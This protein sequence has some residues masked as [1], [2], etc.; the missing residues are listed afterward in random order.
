MSSLGLSL[1]SSQSNFLEIIYTTSL[2]EDTVA[3]PPSITSRS[4]HRI[5]MLP[6]TSL[7]CF[8]FYSTLFLQFQEP[9]ILM[10]DPE[11]PIPPD[12]TVEQCTDWSDPDAQHSPLREPYSATTSFNLPFPSEKLFLLSRGATSGLVKIVQSP[13]I[14]E[15]EGVVEVEVVARYRYPS[16][17]DYVKVCSIARDGDQNGVGIFVSYHLIRSSLV[18]SIFFFRLQDGRGTYTSRSMLP[19]ISPSR[20]GH[21]HYS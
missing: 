12:I 5:Y 17:L 20:L 1:Y 6:L 4:V 21:H 14:V 2:R 10:S 16:A 11:Y 15:D 13:D 18:H 19:Y 3:R 8:R 7:T 9:L